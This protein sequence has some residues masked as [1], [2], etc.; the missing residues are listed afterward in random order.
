MVK[1]GY[2]VFTSKAFERID[3]FPF[4]TLFKLFLR[5]LHSFFPPPHPKSKPTLTFEVINVQ[6][7][8]ILKKSEEPLKATLWS[9]C[10]NK[11]NPPISKW[12]LMMKKVAKDK[13]AHEQRDKF[14]SCFFF[15][16]FIS[17]TCLLAYLPSDKRKYF[18]DFLGDVDECR[19]SKE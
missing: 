16:F 15:V 11:L 4:S 5:P 17:P 12:R 13:F 6:F 19:W 1:Y 8:S 2:P 18:F 7:E 10:I 9:F 3:K 14:F